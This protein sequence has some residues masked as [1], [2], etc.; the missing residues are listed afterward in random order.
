[1]TNHAPMDGNQTVVFLKTIS[2]KI[3]KDFLEK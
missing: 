2:N 3:N 1:M